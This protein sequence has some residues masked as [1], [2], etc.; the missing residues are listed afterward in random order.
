M[1][2]TSRIFK[3]NSWNWPLDNDPRPRGFSGLFYFSDSVGFCIPVPTLRICV[4][5]ISFRT[6]EWT[7]GN[8]RKGWSSEDETIY[9]TSVYERLGERGAWGMTA[10]SGGLGVNPQG[11][12]NHS[13]EKFI[14]FINIFIFKHYKYIW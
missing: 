11:E 10:L 7:W 2:I 3:E 12:K 8:Y 5:W 13:H 1:P 6:K 4:L 14:N 9:S